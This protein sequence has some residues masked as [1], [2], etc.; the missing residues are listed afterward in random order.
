MLR[1]VVEAEKNGR[2]WRVR[3]T[4]TDTIGATSYERKEDAEHEAFVCNSGWGV[5]SIPK[6]R[7]QDKANA[8]HALDSLDDEADKWEAEVNLA[9]IAA[10]MDGYPVRIKAMMRQCFEEGMYRCA[11][12]G[13]DAH[14]E[15]V[16]AAERSASASAEV[17]LRDM[18]SNHSDA[19]FGELNMATFNLRAALAK[20][21]EGKQP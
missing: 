1:Y 7:E 9:E 17:L 2:T 10:R 20:C 11:R 8:A 18:Q 12:A 13:V 14:A 3:N 4:V 15:L 6:A 21:K 16:E 5:A 19:A